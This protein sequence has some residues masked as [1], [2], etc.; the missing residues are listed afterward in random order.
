MITKR[1]RH[2]KKLHASALTVGLLTA[3]PA[4]LLG[5]LLVHFGDRITFKELHLDLDKH[6]GHTTTLIEQ[7]LSGPMT[8]VK[9]MAADDATIAALENPGNDAAVTAANRLM[10]RYQALSGVSVTGLYTTEGRILATYKGGQAFVGRDLSF[11]PYFRH[12]MAGKNYQ[13]FALGHHEN[14]RGYYAA[15]P[16]RGHDDRILGVAMAKKAIHEQGVGMDMADLAFFVSPDGIIFLSN[17]PDLLY[18]AIRPIAAQRQR[19][20]RQTRQFGSQALAPINIDWKPD[21]REAVWNNRT[22][23]FREASVGPPGWRLFV[24]KDKKPVFRF[25]WIM[26]AIAMGV[27]LIACLGILSVARKKAAA[28]SLEAANADLENRVKERTAELK[29]SNQALRTQIAEREAVERALK[30]SNEIFSAIDAAARDAIVMIDHRGRVTYWSHACETILGYGREEMI[31]RDL[32]TAIAPERF[33]AAWRSAFGHFKKTGKGR[34]VGKTVELAAH[35]KDGDEIPI[36][37]S[38]SSIRVRKRWHAVGILRDITERKKAEKAL[39]ESELKYRLLAETSTDVIWTMDLDFNYTYI[40]PAIV[41]R[42]GWNVAEAETLTIAD[43]LTPE[44]MEIAFKRFEAHMAHGTRTGDY[45]VSDR[46]EMELYCKDGATIWAEI[47]VSFVLGADGKPTGIQGVT[48]DITEQRASRMERK[49]LQEKLARSRKMEAL[50]LLAGGV[51][52]DLNNVLSGI[53]SYPDLLLMDL[54]DG[55]P[56]REPIETMKESGQKAAAI[57]QDLLTLARRGVKTLTPLNL[58]NIVSGYLSSPEHRKL[59]TYHPNTRVHTR[60]EAG[61]PNIQGSSHQ[62]K[63]AVMNLVSNAAEALVGGGDITIRTESR[64]LDRPVKGYDRIIDDDRVVLSVAD[65]GRGIS[66]DDL[67]RIFE[68]FYTKKAMGRSGTGLGMAVVWGT[69]QDHSG[70]IDVTSTEGKGTTFDLYFPMTEAAIAAVQAPERIESF[71][72]RNE[73]ILVVDDMET[74]RKIAESILAKLNYRVDTVPGGEAAIAYLETRPVDLVL[75]DMIM[76]P[77][78]DGL[79][80]YRR[81]LQIYPGQKAVIASGFAETDRVKEAH[82]IGV[83]ATIKKP[84]TLQKIGRT[85]RDELDRNTDPGGTR[86]LARSA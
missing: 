77:G 20:I 13:Y 52:H 56:L 54:P 51:A 40:S 11:R 32:H 63:K 60:F 76:D 62:L 14:R 18:K 48:R 61:L 19:A 8:V 26:A 58:N 65:N 66:E 36:E 82:R 78:M 59:L 64:H 16:V 6:L 79:D 25:R 3:V 84:Y 68:P 1:L 43:V 70:T 24:F 50:G 86:R 4:I 12:A 31:G 23:I 44:S 21:G 2:F 39:R 41:R 9:L 34:A 74:Q 85:V 42:H 83:G 57:V 67:H 5:W 30:D 46:F 10:D 7:S 33:H 47:V 80:T 71:L 37:L 27:Y 75:L 28:R 22:Y 17:I 49:E 72:G 15:A 69:V 55:S 73:T 29:S 38:L 81:I 53:V 45:G 35:R